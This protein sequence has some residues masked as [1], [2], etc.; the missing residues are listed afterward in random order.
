MVIV[1]ILFLAG[2]LIRE[3]IKVVWYD[4]LEEDMD[5]RHPNASASNCIISML[6]KAKR[7]SLI[8]QL[9]ENIILERPDLA[10]NT[11]SYKFG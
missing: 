9:F 7:S 3:E 4:T 6:T 11:N 2:R 1:Q 10:D 5:E 8:E